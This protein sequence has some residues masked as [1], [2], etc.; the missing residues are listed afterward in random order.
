MSV[1]P[2][3][4]RAVAA[5]LARTWRLRVFG[6]TRVH[7]ARRTG[8][9]L[10]AVWHGQ[11][12]PPLWHRR[13]EGITLLVSGHRD[14]AYLSGPARAWGYTV[15]HGSSTR[16]GARGLRGLI[17]TLS[18]GHDAAITPDGPRGPARLAKPGVLAAAARAGARVIPVAAT[19]SRSWRLRSWDRFVLPAPGATVRVTYGQPLT[20]DAAAP[21][22]AALE[23][24]REAM[25]TCEDECGAP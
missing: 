2:T 9:V 23:R 3:A 22:P 18:A 24:F 7:E 17:Q 15:V 20:L 11:L 6:E 10:F 21:R 16:G 19:A 12:L 14:A 4:L 1:L 13:Q 5:G 25:Q 8:P